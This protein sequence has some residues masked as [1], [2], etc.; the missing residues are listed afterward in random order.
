MQW[1]DVMGESFCQNY[2]KAGKINTRCLEAGQGDPLVLLH[3]GGGYAEA[4]LKNLIPLSKNFHVY[5]PDMIGHG[6]TDAPEVDYKIPL[7]VEHLRDFLDAARIKQAHISG[8]SLGGWVAAWMAIEH[9]ER[10]RS[11]ILNTT[12]GIHDLNVP[13]VAKLKARSKEL[14][15]NF[16]KENV[17]KRIEWLFHNPADVTDEMVEV[18]FRI[19]ARPG[20]LKA[21]ESWFDWAFSEACE[22]Y[23]L[24]PENVKKI[25]VPT[26]ILWTRQ[27]PGTTWQMAEEKLHKQ[28]PESQFVVMD[29]C[30]H[31]P[32]WEQPEEFNKILIEFF[33]SKS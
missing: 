11:V 23:R 1:L 14:A 8:E 25:K 31:W 29:N 2:Y 10:V 4:F 17:K 26:L 6:F 7:F 16:T 12:A 9:S 27:N 21:S 20:I 5:V 19:Y 15:A 33:K 22:P 24:I 32:Q 28:L 30:G 18:R 3:G 13:G